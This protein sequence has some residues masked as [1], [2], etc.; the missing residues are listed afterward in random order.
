MS[1]SLI[2]RFAVIALTVLLTCSCARRT[3]TVLP[4]TGSINA[5][6]E[7]AGMVDG[8]LAE[9]A[10]KM[11]VKADEIVTVHMDTPVPIPVTGSEVAKTVVPSA[12]ERPGNEPKTPISAVLL[13]QEPPKQ[14][15]SVATEPIATKPQID[16]APVT[17]PS[18]TSTPL[19]PEA[20]ADDAIRR[21]GTAL[22]YIE[23]GNE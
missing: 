6:S 19:E 17:T 7:S 11:V 8:I 9:T 13:R 23:S 18:E 3:S 2:I 14:E 21:A 15:P 10:D 5:N 12:V 1:K 16:V 4:N 22:S 20:T